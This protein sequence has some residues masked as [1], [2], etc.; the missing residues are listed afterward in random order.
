M[1][2]IDFETRSEADIRRVGAW[3]YAEDPST[4]PLCMAYAIDDSPVQLWLPTEKFPDDLQ[5]ALSEGQLVE[6]HNAFF[7]RAIWHNV[8]VP[9]YDWPPMPHDRWACSAARAAAHAI[10][11]SLQDAGT[12]MKITHQ[13]DTAGKA[14][15]LKMAKKRKLK[16]EPKDPKDWWHEDPEDYETL[17]EYCKDDVRAERSLSEKLAHLNPK[18]RVIWLLDQKINERGVRVD[19][20]AVTGAIS[21]IEEYRQKFNLETEKIT[22][23]F[24]DSV[25]QVTKLMEW[26]YSQ[27][28]DMPNVNKDTVSKMLESD[29]LPEDVRKILEI[30]QQLSKTSTA[31]YMKIQDS[32]CSDG[33][34]RDLLMYHGASTGRWTGKMVQPQ[35]FPRN[36]FEGDFEELFKTISTGSLETFE[37]KY[38]DVMRTLSSTIRGIFIPS[39]GNTFYGG[40]YSAIEAR[41]VLW[42]AD[43]DRGLKL[44]AEGQDLYVDM[45]KDIFGTESIDQKQR[46][47]GK[48][49][50]LGC[51]Y[52]MGHVKFQ[53]T[54]ASYGVEVPLE[55]AET[56]IKS[57]RSKYHSITRL[58][59]KQ[60]KAA[61][62][63]V[64]TGKFVAEKP[65][66]WS[67][68]G[69]FLFCRLPSGR[70]IAFH[71]P[72]IEQTNTPWGEVKDS[73]VYDS[74]NSVNRQW[75]ETRTY[76]GKI[77]ENVV[78]GIAR[79]VMAEAMYRC[80]KAGYQVVLSV[81]DELLTEKADGS[82]EEFENIMSH[83]PQWAKGMPI[84]VEGWE[85]KRYLK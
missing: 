7:E 57:Y 17:Y 30:R 6:A 50:I 56:A 62:F 36:T 59:K 70:R 67:K 8:M 48:Q 39:Q 28:S 42:L 13:K 37:A 75:A 2:Y 38:P 79:D 12:V 73:L 16:H 84:S 22:N 46:F 72:R 76:G 11:R 65:L 43:D 35:N 41:V 77:V 23:G 63:A 51:G 45:A 5:K 40:D 33:R 10:P 26:L 74:I 68:E 14:I 81:H 34:L 44:F 47:L 4:R 52:G 69:E 24:L 15:M 31:K 32:I 9:K 80:E 18:E 83:V 1:I 53:A 29:K 25:M 55:L 27:N 82:V 85:G 61:L 54:C 64:E 20:K 60:E 21:I 58:W 66:V 19:E 3:K 49:C 78:Q 71:N